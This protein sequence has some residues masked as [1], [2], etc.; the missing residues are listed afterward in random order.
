[1]T[2]LE[3]R[4]LGSPRF[5]L[6]ER[7][8]VADTRKAFAI[9]AYVAVSGEAHP[10]ESLGA[11]FWP[12]FDESR[13]RAALRRTLSSLKRGV[14]PDVL[15]IN[16]QFV[17]LL[18]GVA[19]I[20]V[21]EF[22]R[23]TEAGD[24]ESLA[25]AVALY[26]DEFMSG[27]TLRDAPPFDE[28]QYYQGEHFRD[29]LLQAL[30]KLVENLTAQGEFEAAIS[31][32]TRWLKIDALREEAHRALMRLYAWTG[33]RSA[34]LNQYRE[35]LRI[36]EQELGVPPLEETE[37]LYQL[38]KQ[39]RL[40]SP[41][42]AQ[43]A[44]AI[45]I[46]PSEAPDPE[47]A[48]TAKPAILPLVGRS[49][50]LQQLRE[51]FD[52][53][54]PDGRLF[55]VE[56]EGGVG[57]TRL[58]QEFL[59]ERQ[60]TGSVILSSRCYEGEQGLAYAPL[61][62]LM[63]AGTK[64]PHSESKLEGVSPHLLAAGMRLMPELADLMAPDALPVSTTSLD[65]PAGQRLFLAGISEILTGFCAGHAPGIILLDDVHWADPATLDWLAFMVRRFENRPLFVIVTVRRGDSPGAGRVRSLVAEAQRALRGKSLSLQRLPLSAVSELVTASSLPVNDEL[66]R[67]L[68]RESEGS[69]FFLVE[70]LAAL[71]VEQADKQ[72]KDISAMPTGVRDLLLSRIAE[73][74][75]TGL[76]LLQ[77]AAVIGRSFGHELMQLASGRSEDEI[78]QGLE[79][80]L[81]LD[82]IRESDGDGPVP[83]YDFNHAKLRTVVYE[84]MSLGR[85]RLL[86]RRLANALKGKAGRS[87]DPASQA[88]QIATHYR[89]AGQDREA[90]QFTMAAADHARELFANAEALD[91]YQTALALGHPA[92]AKIHI[93]CGDLHTRLGSYG[94]AINHFESAASL[95]GPAE[96][97]LVEHRLGKVYFR[98]GEYELAQRQFE[99]AE[100]SWQQDLGDESQARLYADWAYLA[101]RRNDLAQSERKAERALELAQSSND[102]TALSRAHSILGL[103]RRRHDPERSHWHLAHSL[104]F[105][106]EAG[107][108][109]ARVSSLNNLA[110]LESSTGN[111][112]SAL[113]RLEEAL[114]LCR[115]Y[116]DRHR[117]AA[118]LN[119]LA[120]LLR[121]SGQTEA[122][123]SRVITAVEILAE[124]DRDVGEWQPEIWKL[125]E[126]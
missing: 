12:E 43:T 60:E 101:H 99:M 90:A 115:T 1:M 4:L 81:S 55:V 74:S 77:T 111:L 5:N 59:H 75:E 31:M 25:A 50:E 26:R 100:R 78:V 70:Y 24:R 104:E 86:H 89:L 3:L 11:M 119:N 85:R 68:Y 7:P 105:A 33:R 106:L 23:L 47:T 94:D 42:L 71:A 82:L 48:R 80:V 120:D 52:E 54:G 125:T 88:G 10:R 126:W 96:K 117:E 53:V 72:E 49:V 121:A 79:D 108:L 67:V 93:A 27:F 19:D 124:I 38:I 62:E 46:A 61:I 103:L 15:D 98:R 114:E 107:Q 39:D 36:L 92:V 17:G 91:Y 84:E 41:K 18:P 118:L 45:A 109:D 14:G 97:A 65:G 13:A 112:D 110:L 6:G 8:I 123:R 9:L 56:G 76:Q 29:L 87:M 69:P 37:M 34:A 66:A 102:A 22:I 113:Q 122:A 58:V 32:A 44:S 28:W 116:G 64:T 21:S 20:D 30:E 83:I 73:A 16:R 40:E 95:A 35:C 63:E 57:K 51:A 2:Q